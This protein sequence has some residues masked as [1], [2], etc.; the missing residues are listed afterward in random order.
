MAEQH[1][2][3]ESADPTV[4]L[5]EPDDDRT[6]PPEALEAPEA[7]E[8]PGRRFRLP[9]LPGEVGDVGLAVLIA[10]V[11]AVAAAL[12]LLDPQTALSSRDPSADAAAPGTVSSVTGT[13]EE[14]A[15]S[16]EAFATEVLTA[17]SDR[18]QPYEQW[19]ARLEPL[20]T[21]GG[22]EAHEFTDPRRLPSLGSLQ[23]TDPGEA[24][25]ALTTTVRFSTRAG[26]F[27]VDLSRRSP[28]APWLANRILFP[29]E[30]SVFG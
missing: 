12:Y 16:A 30:E 29:G 6:D 2:H 15:G 4:T 8:A 20:L 1:E 25:D 13:G 3:V 22:R 14:S 18:Q 10:L 17:W 24:G 23:A 7:P 19:W 26:V 27:G 11:V 21:S 9:G 28:E 5:F